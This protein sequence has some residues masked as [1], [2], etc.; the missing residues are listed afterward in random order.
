MHI[1][2][3]CYSAKLFFY[4]RMSFINMILLILISSVILAGEACIN[5]RCPIGQYYND[6]TGSCVSSCFP[7]YGNWDTGK[8]VQGNTF[9]CMIKYSMYVVDY[10]IGDITY[11]H[12]ITSCTFIKVLFAIATYYE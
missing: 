5:R 6:T 12:L 7:N 3:L 11:R 4:S 10:V 2:F 9:M 8:C 1:N